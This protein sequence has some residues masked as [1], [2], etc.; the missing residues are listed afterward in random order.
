MSK[1][2]TLNSALQSALDTATDQ[3]RE[4]PELPAGWAD[5]VAT[6]LANDDVAQVEA[7]AKEI[8][9]AHSQYPAEFDRKGWLYDLREALLANKLALRA[10]AGGANKTV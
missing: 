6:A 4:V 5:R 7:L 10:A 2:L 3:P 8:A 1:A 9:T